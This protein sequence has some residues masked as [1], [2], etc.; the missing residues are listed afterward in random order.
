MNTENFI[1]T[2]RKL[3]TKKKARKL[4]S[5]YLDENNLEILI[6]HI[7]EKTLY[8]YVFS[9]TTQNNILLLNLGDGGDLIAVKKKKVCI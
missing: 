9:F 8:E 6:D 7:C 2:N 5:E 4:F 1:L 3:Y